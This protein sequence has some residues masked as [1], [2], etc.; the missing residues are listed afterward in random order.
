MQRSGTRSRSKSPHS[1]MR[2]KDALKRQYSTSAVRRLSLSRSAI[3][4]PSDAS[5]LR[6]QYTTLR[7]RSPGPLPERGRQHAPHS[8]HLH[9]HPPDPSQLEYR[10]NQPDYQAPILT[11]VKIRRAGEEQAQTFRNRHKARLAHRAYLR[12]SFNRMDFIAVVS[13]WIALFLEVTGVMSRHHIYVFRMLSCLRI[14]RLLAITEGTS[15]V[16]QA[17][18]LMKQTI[19]RSLKKAAPLLVP[20]AFFIGFFWVI[21]AIIGIQTFR[22][23]FRRQCVWVGRTLFA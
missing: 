3:T 17:S 9:P 14:F 1:P 22:G 4:E 20:V 16:P 23:S 18:S 7:T 10:D 13:Y 2:K 12:H 15:V 11:A 6:R 21:F 5:Q 19:L 8:S